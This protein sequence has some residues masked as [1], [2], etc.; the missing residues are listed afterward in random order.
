LEPIVTLTIHPR[1]SRDQLPID[2][3]CDVDITAVLR[4]DGKEAI[5]I[6]PTAA[7]LSPIISYAGIGITWSLELADAKGKPCPLFELRTYF[8]PPG[9][10]PAPSWA[11]EQAVTLAPGATHSTTFQACWFPNAALEPR[12]LSMKAFDPTGMNAQFF[13]NQKIDFAKAS[14][15]VMNGRVAAFDRSRDD[16]LSGRVIGLVQEPRACELRLGYMQHSFMNVGANLSSTI[17]STRFEVG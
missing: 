10:P 17:A 6:Y 11:N 2:A 13:K 9:N 1:A 14:V 12:H 5:T 16:F 4:N 7:K 15:F 3:P 8:G